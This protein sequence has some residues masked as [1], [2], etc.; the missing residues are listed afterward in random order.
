MRRTTRGLLELQI[1]NGHRLNPGPEVRSFRR[2]PLNYGPW[3]QPVFIIT[4]YLWLIMNLEFTSIDLNQIS[5]SYYH[6]NLFIS[7]LCNH[8]IISESK[9]LSSVSLS[10]G[11]LATFPIDFLPSDNSSN[12]HLSVLVFN[13]KR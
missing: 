13:N 1:E 10:V 6:N 3:P 11:N 2:L 5:C 8:I 7:L 9:V 4:V 12:I